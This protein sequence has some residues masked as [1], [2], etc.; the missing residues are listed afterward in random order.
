MTDRAT[1]LNN[2]LLSAGISVIVGLLAAS[3][4]LPANWL[5]VVLSV[6]ICVLLVYDIKARGLYKGSNYPFIGLFLTLQAVTGASWTGTLVA[7]YYALALTV[8]FFLFQRKEQ[9]KT[10]FLIYLFCGLG[11]LW[12][13][14]FILV[15]AS[16]LISFILM[17]SFSFR[18]LVAALLG[19]ITPLIIL[20][21]FGLLDIF[22]LIEDYMQP[23]VI[24][25]NPDLIFSSA[26]ALLSGLVM[27]LPSYGY[28]AKQRARNMSMLGLTV[29][30]IVMPCVDFLNMGQYM[31]LLNLCA[32][33]NVAHFA[34]TRRY[35]WIGCLI[36]LIASIVFSFSI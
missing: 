31:P 7:L 8:M 20:G 33:Y 19:L 21:G 4:M 1:G 28:P 34:A 27:F 6:A 12:L 3:M 30:A 11:A 24:G 16:I 23:F 13:R 9:T 35:G 26:V 29:C 32:A 10:I 2:F 17:R 14:S 25:Y 22:T 15:G 18:G 5:M 36:V